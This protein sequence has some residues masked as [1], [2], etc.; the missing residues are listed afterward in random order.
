MYAQH[1]SCIWYIESF[2]E[3]SDPSAYQRYLS[4]DH[5]SSAIL[6]MMNFN[7][8]TL[9]SILIMIL[10]CVLP[11]FLRLIQSSLKNCSPTNI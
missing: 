1:T 5:V 6:M 11:F 9:I 3:L 8:S 4:R 7:E 10:I 2:D